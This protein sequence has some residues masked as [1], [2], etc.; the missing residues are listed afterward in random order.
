MVDLVVQF[1]AKKDMDEVSVGIMI[2]DK[3]G[4]DIFGTNTYHHH[5]PISVRRGVMTR[6][7]FAFPMNISP[8]EYTITAALHTKDHHLEH[9]M[10]WTDQLK[11]FEVV[12][13]Q[14]KYFSG[15]CRLLPTIDVAFEGGL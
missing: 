5:L 7:R 9:C 10:H 11:T 2:R 15:L 1:N 8:G 6:C 4:Q 3:F 13:I 14:G 12:G